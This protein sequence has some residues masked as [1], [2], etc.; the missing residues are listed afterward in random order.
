MSMV[1][2]T[3]GA[4]EG[5]LFALKSLSKQAVVEGSQVQHIKDEKKVEGPVYWRFRNWIVGSVVRWKKAA[6]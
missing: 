5:G 4:M 1:R 2:K 3:G 6:T